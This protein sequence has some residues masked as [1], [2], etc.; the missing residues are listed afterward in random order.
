[1]AIAKLDNKRPANLCS[2][3]VTYIT[4]ESAADSIDFHNL[5]DLDAGDIEERRA[6]AIAYAETREIDAA[7][8]RRI[9]NSTPKIG[10]D[11]KEVATRQD[12]NHTTL[13]LSWDRAENTDKAKEM[14]RDFLE[15]E[16]KNARAIY[17]IHTDKQGQTHSHVWIDNKLESGKKLQIKPERFYTLDERWAKKYDREYGT[18]YAPRFKELKRETLEWKKEKAQ[19]KERGEEFTKPKPQRVNDIVK[20]K[21][22]E[23]MREREQ[24][25]RGVKTHDKDGTGR[26]EPIITN[27]HNE[28][29]DSKQRIDGVER[30]LD[31]A[32]AAI[33]RSE[34][35]NAERSEAARGAI[36]EAQGL[37][38]AIERTRLE[39]ERDERSDRSDRSD[40]GRGRG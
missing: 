35:A 26:S 5:K 37:R 7:A 32:D 29:E 25:N 40:D 8:N 38:E 6:A 34:H 24:A 19:A 14:T 39:Q 10:K 15:K 31:V 21:I 36:H 17:T 9:K 23:K 22:K 30:T 18:E 12:R 3:N 13:I 33:D 2:Q 4:R 27:G 20:G 16:F 28:I 11:G 1:M